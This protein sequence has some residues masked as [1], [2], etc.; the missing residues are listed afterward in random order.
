MDLTLKR[1]WEMSHW[2]DGHPGPRL[3]TGQHA[4]G[5]IQI[6]CKCSENRTITEN[7]GLRRQVR[8]YSLRF[9]GRPAKQKNK[10][11]N[12]INILLRF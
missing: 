7:K 8:T 2:T 5:L 3:G 12:K 10:Q 11:A 6:A 4:Q 9:N 1:L